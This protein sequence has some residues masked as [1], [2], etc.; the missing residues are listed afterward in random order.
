MAQQQVLGRQGEEWGAD[1]LSSRGFAI[2][3]RNWR[4]GTHEIDIVAEK[5]GCL[6]FVEVKLRSSGR[7][8]PPEVAVNKAKFGFLKQAAAAYLRQHPRFRNV[9]FDVLSVTN[10]KDGPAYYFIEDVFF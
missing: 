6:H 2:R 1:F 3:H 10:G 5:N 4:S 8:G 9:R 7:Y